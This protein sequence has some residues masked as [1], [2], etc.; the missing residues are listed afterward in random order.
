MVTCQSSGAYRRRRA[1]VG[2][3]RTPVL[4]TPAHGVL[5]MLVLGRRD[6]PQ[7]LA[8][9]ALGAVLP[10]LPMLLF[11]AVHKLALGTPEHVIWSSAYF[12]PA[13]QGIFDTAH[14]LPLIAL[15]IFV[16]HRLAWRR[17]FLVLASMALHAACDL[18]LHH[19]DAHRHFFPLTDWRFSSA[20]S[21]WDPAHYGRQFALFEIA[22]VA[23]GSATL[24]RRHRTGAARALVGVFVGI[25]VLFIG[26]ALTVWL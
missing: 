16:T 6:R 1:Y 24:L 10:D 17:A 8:P 20:L 25:Y 22:L 26:F 4:N 13:W 12:Q 21:Y 23:V 3:A 18:P 2:R 9:I 7:E 19:D 15:G 14:S 5:A 11:Y